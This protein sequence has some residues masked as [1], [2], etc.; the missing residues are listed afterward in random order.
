[1]TSSTEAGT[2]LR[3]PKVID[4]NLG[5]RSYEIHVGTGLID[6]AGQLIAPLLARPKT[7]IVTD[8][9]VGGAVLPS[10]KTS[11][12]TVGIH[13]DCC[14]LP[15]GEAT[16][17]FAHLQKLTDTMLD[18]KIERDDMVIALGGGV[19]GDLTGFAASILRRGVDFIQ[20]PTSLL[21]QVDSSVG[22]KTGINT[23][24]GKNLIGAFHQPR[25][26]LAD[27]NVLTSLPER[28][29]RAGYAEVVKYGLI[30]QPDFFEWL[31][32]NGPSLLAGD[33][34][35]RIYAIANSC[36]SKAN[37]VAKDEREQGK[38]ALLN[39]GH[40][41][42]H[43]LEAETN[44]SDR[45]NHGEGVSIGMCLAHDFSVTEGLGRGQDTARVK[46]HL[47][48]VGLPTEIRDIP[49]KP[50]SA[51]ALL[52]HMYQD[53]KSSGGALT[54]ILTEGIGKAFVVKDVDP[55]NLLTFL[56]TRV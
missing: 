50:M 46:A 18:A 28:E 16:K 22:G 17:S 20:I 34:K 6:Q 47:R 51:D 29:L 11:L 36:Q 56:K 38:R 25:L 15:P 53:K 35:A 30:D 33:V 27:V 4:V 1:M 37:I 14:V 3:I 5:E 42:G 26:V 21:A 39:L 23:K 19:I 49:G 2:P 24:F 48:A 45:L 41:F 10:L 12:E 40:T 43:A 9:H 55:T 54:F 44:Y 7:L 52:E 32:A 8:D 13:V 31:E